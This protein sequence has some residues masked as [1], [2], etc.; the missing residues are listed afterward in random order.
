MALT[1]LDP[2]EGLF[3]RAFFSTT[4]DASSNLAGVFAHPERITGSLP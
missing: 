1:R 2:A 4:A 3:N